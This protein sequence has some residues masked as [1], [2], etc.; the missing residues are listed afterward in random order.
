MNFPETPSAVRATWLLAPAFYKR[1]Q[2]QTSKKM[3][4]EEF[5]PRPRCFRAQQDRRRVSSRSFKRRL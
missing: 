2:K 5:L 4:F 3:G 1:S